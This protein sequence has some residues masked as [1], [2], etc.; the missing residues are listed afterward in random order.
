MGRPPA[1]FR[2][3]A[4]AEA[5]QRIAHGMPVADFSCGAAWTSVDAATTQGAAATGGAGDHGP[6]EPGMA[7][8]FLMLRMDAPE[9]L[10]SHDFE[11][12]LVRY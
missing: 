5:R 3:L 4:A 9:C 12:V 8:D 7:A 1:A 2:N 6:L 11:W 10:P